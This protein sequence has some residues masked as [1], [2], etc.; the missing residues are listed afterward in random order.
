MAAIAVAYETDFSN[1]S[2]ALSAGT[3]TRIAGGWTRLHPGAGPWSR[4]SGTKRFP[5][6]IQQAD[7]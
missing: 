2:A 7:S 5:V 3:P 4:I 1:L 6:L